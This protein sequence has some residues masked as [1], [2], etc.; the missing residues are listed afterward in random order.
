VRSPGA[1]FVIFGGGADC[2]V[3]VGR[4]TDEANADFVV[5]KRGIGRDCKLDFSGLGERDGDRVPQDSIR[6]FL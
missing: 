4:K 2:D 5:N 6:N 3:R 1:I